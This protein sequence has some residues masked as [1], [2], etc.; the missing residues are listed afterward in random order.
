MKKTGFDVEWRISTYDILIP[1][2]WLSLN[3]S[4]PRPCPILPQSLANSVIGS[5]FFFVS[6]RELHLLFWEYVEKKS[7]NLYYCNFRWKFSSAIIN[8]RRGQKNAY[9]RGAYE[10]LSKCIIWIFDPVTRNFHKEIQNEYQL[11]SVRSAICCKLVFSNN[12]LFPK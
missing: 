4:L 3:V 5:F 1:P 12:L 2:G 9:K 8:C 6:W 10:T 7:E 11:C